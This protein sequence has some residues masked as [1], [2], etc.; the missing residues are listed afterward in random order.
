VLSHV[1][2]F[3]N[4]RGAHVYPYLIRKTKPK[5]IRVFL[6]AG[7]NDLDIAA[8]H[9]PLANLEMA[10]ALN[11]AGYDY[12]LEYGDGGHDGQHGGVILPESLLWL[13]R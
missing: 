13:W 10:A 5:P 3:T 1:G 12:R 11:F 8:G 4:L 7:S 6:Q 9:W 2:S